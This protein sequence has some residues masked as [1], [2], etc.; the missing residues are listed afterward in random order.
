MTDAELADVIIDR[1]NAL[2]R[3]SEIANDLAK[4]IEARVHCSLKASEHPSLQVLQIKEG[5]PPL[6]GFL[7]VLN[8]LVGVV[9]EG[10]RQGWGYIGADFDDYGNL[11]RF[12]RTET[13]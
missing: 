7:G 3:D 1:L 6:L 13:V 5:E 8:G 4:L 11:L 10:V 12:K 9:P 2:I